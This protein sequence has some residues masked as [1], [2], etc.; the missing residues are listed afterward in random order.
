[1]KDEIITL[2]SEAG[3][4]LGFT[5]DL[6]GGWLWGDG[7]NV[8]ISMIFSLKEGQGNL[9][10]L[11]D[12]IESKGYGIVVPTPVGKM[13]LICKKRGMKEAFIDDE[14]GGA[15]CMVSK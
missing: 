2:D 9:T 8:V 14:L 13:E 10:R 3:K 5:S 4:E 11:F 6:F 7:E 1:M 12:A 15:E